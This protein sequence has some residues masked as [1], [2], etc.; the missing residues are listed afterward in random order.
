MPLPPEP[1]LRLNDVSMRFGAK[2]VLSPV[3]LV[4]RAGDFI[5]VS[6]SNG[7]GK[8]TLLRIMLGLL[9]PATGSVEYLLNGRRVSYIST[10]YLP[11]KSSV[12][13]HFPL[14]VREVIDSGL[15]TSGFR[16]PSVE[17]LDAACAI[18]EHFGLSDLLDRVL[19]DLSGGQVQRALI[20]RA[21]VS[22]PRF[23]VFDEPFSYL[24][25]A[26]GDLLTATLE[27]LRG[28]A[29]VVMVSHRRERIQK[30][31]TRRWEVDH[32]VTEIPSLP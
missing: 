28:T 17:D 21:L 8:T 11:Q 30:L 16:R 31:A 14:T 32:G 19:G 22:R 6:G 24:D 5:A 18:S 27:E 10:G 26:N 15:L 13:S 29:T 4:I 7:G 25:R 20:A 9:R 12:D 23:I 2:T 3:S 1:L